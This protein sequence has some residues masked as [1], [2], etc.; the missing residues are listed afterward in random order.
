M[1]KG[2]SFALEQCLRDAFVVCRCT[3]LVLASLVDRV[4]PC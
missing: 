2:S 1:G 3:G 4:W